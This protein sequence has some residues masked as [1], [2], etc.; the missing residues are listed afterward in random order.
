MIMDDT[1]LLTIPDFCRTLHI[2]PSCARRWV[3]ERK[4]ATIKVGRLVRIP[5][6]E[7]LR[8]VGDGLRPRAG[9]PPCE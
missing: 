6:E 5:R 3:L 9:E 1:T 7:L 2:T 4:I 8:I